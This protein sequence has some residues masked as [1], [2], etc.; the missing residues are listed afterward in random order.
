MDK[1]ALCVTF[2]LISKLLWL[3]EETGT[4]LWLQTNDTHIRA[5]RYAMPPNTWHRFNWQV[6]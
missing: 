2:R 6:A 4:Y 1:K 5:A 3:S